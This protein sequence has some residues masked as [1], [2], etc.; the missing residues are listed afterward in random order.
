LKID[1]FDDRALVFSL[2][3]CVIENPLRIHIS[4]RAL[5]ITAEAV[6]QVFKLPVSGKSL[7]NYNAADKRAR[8]HVHQ[9]IQKVWNPCSIGMEATMLGWGLVKSP[10]GLFNIMP[11]RKKLMWMTELCSH[12]SYLCSMHYYFQLAATKWQA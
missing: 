7:P 3:S 12:S 11:M 10:G 9:V 8:I 5:S 2:L 4:N 1:K 6:Q